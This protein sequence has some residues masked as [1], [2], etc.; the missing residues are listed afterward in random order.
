MTADEIHRETSLRREDSERI[1]E[2]LVDAPAFVVAS[3]RA[4]ISVGCYSTGEMVE[5]LHA[6]KSL[7]R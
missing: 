2:V 7:A 1:A 3:F 4:M 6:L 5:R